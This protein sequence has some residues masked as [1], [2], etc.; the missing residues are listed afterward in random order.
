MISNQKY[1]IPKK[2]IR[3]LPFANTHLNFDNLREA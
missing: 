3:S 1:P 2:K